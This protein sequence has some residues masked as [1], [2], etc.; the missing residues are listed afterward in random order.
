[1]K[2]HIYDIKIL[3]TGNLGEGTQ[4]YHSYSRNYTIASDGKKTI[5]A[6]SDPLFKGDSDKYNPEELLLAAIS[7]CHML[8]YL[9]LCSENEIVVISYS[10]SSQG[11]MG[12]NA[13]GGGQ[14][15]S[16]TLRPEITIS[17]KSKKALAES[18]HAKAHKKCFISN[19]LNFPVTINPIIKAKTSS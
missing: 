11:V 5:H 9:H 1:M 15:N 8:W 18:L 10:D 2:E 3:W 6:S 19:S 12:V 7:S 16:V 13:D 14:F 4:T 17:D